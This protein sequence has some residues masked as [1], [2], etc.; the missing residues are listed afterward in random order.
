VSERP[1][2]VI[3]G[4][5]TV[6][7]QSVVKA[8][9]SQTEIAVRIVTVDASDQVAGRYFSDAFYRVPPAADPGFVGSLLHICREERATLLIPIVDYEF[10]PL[11][12][13]IEEFSAIGTLA[14][15]SDP[16]VIGTVNDKLSTYRF[17]VD[18][19]FS[20]AKTW[21]GE[22]ARR[23]ASQLAYPV[24]LKPA[25]DGRSSLDCYKVKNRSDLELYLSQVSQPI[26]Q[27]FIDA[28]EYTADVLADWNSLAKGVVI[29]ERI[30]TKG[31]VSYKGRTVRDPAL[32]DEIVRM[33]SLLGL[34]GPANIQA[35]RRG[36]EIFFNEINPRFSG[37]LALSLAAGLN[38]PL[39][40]LKIALGLPV[41]S[42]LARTCI[43]LTMLRYWD[44][45]FVDGTGNPIYP[46]YQLPPAGA[47]HFGNGS[48]G[49]AVALP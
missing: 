19:G 6:T 24:F 28:P 20:T 36:G 38:S 44:E 7:C 37:A 42:V 34:H 13:A 16:K 31:G 8:F 47:S 46:N 29:R 17:F 3:T 12:S 15:M 18:H 22:E 30:E 27:E 2:V 11:S 40:L 41:K 10:K 45:V 43:G 35:F 21:T 39:M 5:G 26:V 1:T 49:L 25:I 32:E 14:G 48:P 9:R 4:S 23:L 33:V